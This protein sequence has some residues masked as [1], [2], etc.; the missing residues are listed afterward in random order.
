VHNCHAINSCSDKPLVSAIIPTRNRPEKACRAARSALCQTYKNLEV[1]VVVD[2]PDLKTI[3]AL[4]SLDDARLRVIDLAVN[5]GGSEA[6]NVG[7][8]ESRGSF[9][10]L[11]DDDDESM[12]DKI[13]AQYTALVHSDFQN[14]IVVCNYIR[15]KR[16]YTLVRVRAP[17]PDE[18][19]CD[20]MFYSDCLFK[21]YLNHLP[22]TD[23]Y[24]ASREVFLETPFTANL[25]N[26][27]DW[28]WLLRAMSNPAR[29]M[30]VVPQ[31]LVLVHADA[32]NDSVSMSTGWRTSLDWIDTVKYLFTPRSYCGFITE[33]C[34]RR[35][36]AF[37]GRFHIFAFLLQR[38]RKSGDLTLLQLVVAGKWFLLAPPLRR[39]KIVHALFQIFGL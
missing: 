2:G 17:R 39:S 14:P 31:S 32:S 20:Y 19:I 22:V 9:I 24:L 13:E 34:M 23:C 21:S 30:V 37:K 35:I 25:P 7:I 27:Q 10:A 1:V 16:T 15:H 8:R 29:R 11:L 33:V 3:E 18:A 5:V 28:D 36:A 6:R 38:C 26:H 4:A 12:P